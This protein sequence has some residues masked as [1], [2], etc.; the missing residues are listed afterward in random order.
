VFG[1]DNKLSNFDLSCLD[2]SDDIDAFDDLEVL[3]V[4]DNLEDIELYFYL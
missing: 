2:T 1:L 4:L 3:E